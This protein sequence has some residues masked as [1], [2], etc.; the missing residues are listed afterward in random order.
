M[1]T[2]RSMTL[3]LAG[4]FCAAAVVSCNTNRT[5][6]ATHEVAPQP[7]PVADT[8]PATPPVTT[9]ANDATVNSGFKNKVVPRDVQTNSDG[10]VQN[11]T[12]VK[13]HVRHTTSDSQSF[14]D[15]HHNSGLNKFTDPSKSEDTMDQVAHSNMIVSDYSVIKFD[16]GSATLSTTAMS[17]LDEVVSQARSHG[18]I[19]QIR[20]AVWSDRLFSNNKNNLTS[21]DKKLAA[22]RAD[23]IKD[24]LKGTLGISS[25]ALFNMAERS[26]WLAR[27]INT[28]DAEL[29]SVFAKRGSTPVG[30]DEFRIFKENGEPQTAVVTVL[31]R[32]ST[33]HTIEK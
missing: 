11:K 10:P 13:K 23:S 32:S 25:V 27:T 16:E 2:F 3:A 19:D 31:M 33:A 7:V 29:K 4:L 22:Q 21:A 1:N 8:A 26:N 5:V 15:D 20:V 14:N 30:H 6:R 12:T 28:D 17:K 24:Y 18:Q 9:V